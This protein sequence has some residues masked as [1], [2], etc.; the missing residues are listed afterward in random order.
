M[1]RKRR[2][3]QAEYSGQVEK[4]SIVGRDLLTL[5]MKANMSSDLRPDQKLTDAEVVAQIVT[6]VRVT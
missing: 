3:I 2:Q 4:G 6:F 1:R 5:L